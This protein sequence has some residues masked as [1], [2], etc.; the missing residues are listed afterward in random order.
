MYHNK[1]KPKVNFKEHRLTRSRT[2]QFQEVRP[3][4]GLPCR[5]TQ[6]LPRAQRELK[7][8]QTSL[9]QS[10]PQRR[11]RQHRPTKARAAHH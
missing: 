6:F 5:R 1:E 10:A 4:S 8:Q 3:E 11:T 9:R 7:R 2:P